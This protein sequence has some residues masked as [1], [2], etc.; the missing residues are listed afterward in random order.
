M[1]LAAEMKDEPRIVDTDYVL[2]FLLD[3]SQLD[4]HAKK[5]LRAV[6]SHDKLLAALGSALEYLALTVPVNCSVDDLNFRLG[7]IDNMR[8][9]IALAKGAPDGHS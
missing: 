7:T 2:V 9:A 6:N 4:K 1:G 3:R 5:L 8:A